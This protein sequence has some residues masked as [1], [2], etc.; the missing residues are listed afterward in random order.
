MSRAAGGALALLV[1]AAAVG[2]VGPS[3]AS[4]QPTPVC[5]V[6]GQ[7]FHE[8]VTATD[9]TLQVQADGDVAWHVE[10]EVPASTAAEWRKD[11]T[12][13]R[14]L[15][16]D[17]IDRSSTPPYAPTRP[18]VSVEGN[19][20]TIEFVDRRAARQRLGLLV[21][22]Y[23]HGEGVQARYVVNAD[24]I[25]VVAPDGQRVVNEPAGATV[26]GDRAVWRGVASTNQGMEGDEVWDA[27]EP[28]D[29]YV[30]VGAGATAGVRS[31]VVTGFEPLDPR[32]YGWYALGLLFVAGLTY[33]GYTLQR[34][35]FERRV[36]AS[37]V[38]LGVLP[39]LALVAI[40]HPPGDGLGGFFDRLLFAAG[41]L[42]V[43]LLGALL[44]GA[45]AT[46]AVRWSDRSS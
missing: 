13:L 39:Y 10:N 1:I 26:D 18:E 38:V 37:A 4:P 22:P 17:R 2:I 34:H 36:V 25:V 35:R 28:G 46:V 44:L 45:G 24:E 19:T 6:C 11:E 8:N 27:P 40:M 42:L 14:D 31:S 21:V 15:V 33:G 41:S 9:A 20:A 29:T 3:I 16:A 32:L 43:G 23:F 30:V 7:T 5:P 12:A